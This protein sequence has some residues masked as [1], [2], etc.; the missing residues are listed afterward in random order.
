MSSTPPIIFP[1]PSAWKLPAIAT[2]PFA[3]NPFI[4]YANVPAISAS[5]PTGQAAAPTA[6]IVNVK[7][8]DLLGSSTAVAVMV[9]ISLAPEGWVAGGV[10][11]ALVEGP[12]PAGGI[13]DNSPPGLEELLQPP[14]PDVHTTPLV[15]VTSFVTVAFT[16]TAAAAASIAVKGFVI[17]TAMFK[18][19]VP[20]NIGFEAACAQT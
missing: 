8:A 5:R 20:L 3:S 14:E 15:G 6:L 9:G 10:Y 17:A 7:L 2:A 12:G 11:V 4:K 1:V 19:I 18:V 13:G 16:V